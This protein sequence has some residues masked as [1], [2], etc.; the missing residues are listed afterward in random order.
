M[1][2][3][4]EES[5]HTPEGFPSLHVTTYEMCI[6]YACS[7]VRI[8]QINQLFLHEL[9]K[10]VCMTLWLF[11]SDLLDFRHQHLESL[12]TIS[13]SGAATDKVKGTP[14]GIPNVD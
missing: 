5:F 7:R 12:S 8:K 11:I 1:D 3:R 10:I 9:N 2:K 13:C 14:L 4:E 6:G